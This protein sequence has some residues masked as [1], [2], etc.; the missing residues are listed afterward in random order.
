[1]A[2]RTFGERVKRNE[3]PRILR[4]EAT[5]LDDVDDTGALH[6]AFL[7]SPMAHAR[8][9]SI[10]V[11]AAQAHPG[12]VAVFT[13]DDLGALDRPLPLLIPHPAMTHPRTQ[14]PLAR[15]VVSYVGQTIAM[16]VAT[17]RYV[18]EDAVELIEAHYDALPV[19]VDVEEAAAD[20]AALVHADV[21]GN[22][23]CHLVQRSGDPDA[24]FAEADV[25]IRERIEV[26]RSAGM[27]L[28][29]RGVVAR[30]DRRTGALTVWDSTQAPLSIRNGLA[31]MLGLAESNVRVVAPQ[32]GGGFGTKV[33]MFYPEEVL[34]PWAALELGE[35]IKWVEDRVEHFIGSNHERKQIHEIELAARSDGTVIGVRDHFI[36]DT[37]AFIPYG[38]AV[39]QVAAGQIA[40]P[41]R[42]PNVEVGLTAVYTNTVPVSPYRGAG[43]PH[44]CMALELAMEKLAG[45]L[46][47]DRME[48][49]RRNF[50]AKDE[51]PWKRDG[52]I[53][54]D[55]K[56]VNMDSGDYE[57]SLD[58]VLEAIDYAG[59]R[60]EQKRAAAEGRL[61]GL[62]L[63]VYVEGTGLGPYEGARVQVHPISGK[64]H[65][66][67]GLT[68]Q[69]QSHETTFA[70]IIAD[71]LG[72]DA[73]DVEIV[74]GDTAAFPYGVATFASRAAV[75][76][77]SAMAIAATKVREK[78][79]RL[80]SNMLEAA[81]EDLDIERG[82]VFVKGSPDSGITLKQ[83][84]VASNPL[85]YAWDEEAQSA[86]QF[87]PA[88]TTEEAPLPEG[89]E[90]GLEATGYYSPAGSTWASGIH[91][92][93]IE[94]DPE[95]FEVSWHRYVCS[96]DCGK[97]INPTVVEGQVLGGIAQGVGGAMYERLQ[98]DDNGQLRN[99]SFMDFLMPYATEVP[100]VE[101]HHL[102]TPTPLN[103][104]GIKGVGEAG[105]IPVPALFASAVQDALR[106]RGV[107]ITEAPLNPS[108]I[109]AIVSAMDA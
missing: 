81:P 97:M 65:A 53:F 18:A 43:R 32:T 101:V 74:T 48:L 57:T 23:A 72:V 99:A 52:L 91:A 51:F 59:F 29:A 68:T 80:A 49:R 36:H 9:A 76:S 19:L 87:A 67:T 27:P 1:M 63:A 78:A 73:E 82:R 50:I 92:A 42:I 95:T 37:G 83:I 6:V 20:G 89:E 17:D 85:R 75:V 30:H 55:G 109:H 54:A 96:H 21:P 64:V 2:V 58:Q 100:H 12:V 77:G 93:I 10:D 39:A 14:L 107:R 11:S 25:V 4:G 62:G 45:E 102:E 41:Y 70:Q 103:E 94:L 22:V 38:I 61:L 60:E 28:E 13:A 31:S 16:V 47:I 79:I 105:A 33:M 66:A 90:P 88:H 44:A 34:I 56:P 7:R 104:Y 35:A 98:Y 108:R 71:R 86:T 3:D 69:G 106:D 8:I 46:G 26:E 5:Y 40:G 24:A 15:D 84:A